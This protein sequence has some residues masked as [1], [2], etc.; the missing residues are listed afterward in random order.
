MANLTVVGIVWALSDE[1]GFAWGGLGVL[2]GLAMFRDALQTKW[3][4]GSFPKLRHL[5]LSLVK[6]LF[7]LPVWVDALFDRRVKWRGTRLVI[8][9]MTRLRRERA[10]RDV[11]RRVRRARKNR[12]F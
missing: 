7:L 1:T 4:R 9:R 2:L 8:G 12:H 3:L 6:D 5:P 11:R 10:T